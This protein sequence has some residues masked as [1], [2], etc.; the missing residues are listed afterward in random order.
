M[1][2][3]GN[4]LLSEDL[5]DEHFACDLSACKGACCVEGDSGAPLTHAELGQLERAWEHVAP[6]LPDS[7]RAAVDEQGLAVKDAD[8]DLV[9]PLVNG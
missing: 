6:L 7:G 5:F 4:T 8:G 9:T 3:I 1:I 2:R